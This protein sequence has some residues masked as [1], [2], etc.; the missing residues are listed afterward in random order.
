MAI[1]VPSLGW[2]VRVPRE[3][4]LE[5]SPSPDVM[6]KRMLSNFPVVV[7]RVSLAEADWLLAN[8]AL[9]IKG[10]RLE[11]LSGVK[12]SSRNDFWA[13]VEVEGE[14]EELVP[15]EEFS[16]R[17]LAPKIEKKSKKN[18]DGFLRRKREREYGMAGKKGGTRR[19]LDGACGD[20]FLGRSTNYSR[21]LS[22]VLR[23]RSHSVPNG[24]VRTGRLFK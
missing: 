15:L 18:D 19:C 14:P 6:E 13:T 7:N 10:A 1:S 22:G 9:D 8:E 23:S 12:P 20:A 5:T 21:S 4:A 16:G 24:G 3:I 2:T 17:M 11:S